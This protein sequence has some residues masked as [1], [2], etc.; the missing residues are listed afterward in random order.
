MTI[1]LLKI[2]P[3]R[4]RFLTGPR[5]RAVKRRWFGLETATKTRCQQN[6]PSYAVR[7]GRGRHRITAR[8][9]DLTAVKPKTSHIVAYSLIWFFM[10]A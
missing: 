1:Q 4:G 6:T 10:V 9:P 3:A 2:R 5:T 8:W 7:V